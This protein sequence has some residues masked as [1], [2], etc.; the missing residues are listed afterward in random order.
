M[1]ELKLVIGINES[2][3]LRGPLRHEGYLMPQSEGTT[4]ADS[5]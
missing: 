2:A 4:D 5:S 3:C 1:R